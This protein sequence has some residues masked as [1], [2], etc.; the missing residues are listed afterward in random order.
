MLP[1]EKRRI[2][3]V[4]QDYALFPHLPVSGNIAFG[5]HGAPQAAARVAE[6]ARLV[7]L[8]AALEKYPHEISGGQ[9]QRVA[10]LRRAP[11]CCCST[12]RSPT[13]TSTCASGCRP[14][15]ARSSRRAAP[16]RSW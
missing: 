13:W 3:M 2:G 9:Q 4:F 16:P 6:L 8:S 1:P 7:G 15:C 11:T 14:K 5:L 10:L 12:S